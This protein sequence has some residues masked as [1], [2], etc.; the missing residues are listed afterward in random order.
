MAFWSGYALLD[1]GWEH[2]L[3]GKPAANFPDHAL[4]GARGRVDLSPGVPYFVGQL[5]KAF[6][7]PARTP[8]WPRWPLPS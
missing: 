1:P 6:F 3:F 5:G 2:G 4:K 8:R 7:A